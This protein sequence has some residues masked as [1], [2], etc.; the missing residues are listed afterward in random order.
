MVPPVDMNIIARRESI[1][2]DFISL[3]QELQKAFKY[4]GE[5]PCSRVSHSS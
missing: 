5:S 4:I 3:Q 1:E 2:M